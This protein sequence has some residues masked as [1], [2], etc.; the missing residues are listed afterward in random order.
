MKR[1]VFLLILV[2]SFLPL[3]KTES[4]RGENVDREAS[5]AS[6]LFSQIT[7]SSVA[8]CEAYLLGFVTQKESSG[9]IKA[10]LNRLDTTLGSDWLD[11][12]KIEEF[13]EQKIYKPSM[14]VKGII[15]KKFPKCSKVIND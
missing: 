11:A 4:V 1:F 13:Q 5:K 9:M 12:P 3:I 8:I 15:I 7:G 6:L 14:Y 2:L 10:Y